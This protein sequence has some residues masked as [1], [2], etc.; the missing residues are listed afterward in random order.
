MQRCT[1]SAG[2]TCTTLDSN[3]NH[4]QGV[5]TD[6]SNNIFIADTENGRIRK[7]SSEGVCSDFVT[8]Q[9]WLH[10]VAVDSSGMVYGSAAWNAIVI[11]FDSTGALLGT[12][13]GVEFVPY[14]TD[15]FH[16]FH[17]R[18]AIDHADNL[19]MVEE[20]GQRL[21]KLDK[22]GNLKWKIGTPGLDMGWTNDHFSYPQGVAVDKNNFIYVAE[23]C[24][25]Q[26][27]SPDGYY[28]ST[29]GAGCGLG[30]TSLVGLLG[31]L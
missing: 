10:D 26:I 29:I 12:F 30:T 25:V 4:P 23:S 3:L 18:V 15:G 28:Q 9:N 2:W 16:Y 8:N 7:C 21:I 22:D 31:L 13:V 27:F 6:S 1:Y 17:P 11:R 24:R 20:N 5:A 14:L 19:I